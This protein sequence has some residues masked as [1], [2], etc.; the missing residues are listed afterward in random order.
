MPWAEPTANL[1]LNEKG[2]D[3]SKQEAC[4]KTVCG[5]TVFL[6][7]SLAPRVTPA[8]QLDASEKTAIVTQLDHQLSFV[9]HEVI[10]AA[11]A[12]P[13]SKYSFVPTG[14]ISRACGTSPNR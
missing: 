6:L 11:E 10:A 12:M 3:V 9:E 14:V 5:M 2:W 8:Q 1:Y 13:E 4:M 7:L